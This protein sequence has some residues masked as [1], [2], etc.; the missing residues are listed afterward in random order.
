MLSGL[1]ITQYDATLNGWASQ[2]LKSSVNFGAGSS[3]FCDGEASRQVLTNTFNWIITDGGKATNCE[4]LSTNEFDLASV[5]IYPNPVSETLTV[6]LG[7][8]FGI[9]TYSIYNMLG[10]L[11]YKGRLSSSVERVDVSELSTGIYLL[12]LG[13]LG[14][15]KFVKQ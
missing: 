7:S 1:S 15:R 12:N 9:E 8:R 3:Q 6:D 2:S 13:R 4:D 11:V 5:R 10:K 14:T